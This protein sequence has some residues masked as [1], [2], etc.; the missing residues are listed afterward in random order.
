M[1][2]LPVRH[3]NRPGPVTADEINGR[4]DDL[5]PFLDAAIGPAQRLTP[6]GA[7]HARGLEPFRQPFGWR[8]VA[9]QFAGREVAQADRPALCGVSGH[10]PA[11][12]DFNIVRMRTE[13]NEIDRH[14]FDSIAV[15]TLVS[16]LKTWDLVCSAS[17]GK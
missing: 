5:G 6:A 4:P 16:R 1:S 3:C 12:A 9:A 13:D 7:E 14:R 15:F 2:I 17:R 11:E 8:P 10:G